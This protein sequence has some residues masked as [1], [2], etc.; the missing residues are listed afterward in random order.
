MNYRL[1]ITILICYTLSTQGCSQ[2]NKLNFVE[3]EEITS[4]AQNLISN[5]LQLLKGKRIGIIA[6]QT[7][8][9]GETHLVDTLTSLDMDII[10]IFSP[11][12]GFRGKAEA[13]ALI[14]DGI[15][16]KTGIQII[17]LY[18]NHKKPTT[19][20]LKGIDLVL[21]DLQ[22]V[23]VRF[24]TYISTLTYIME[25]CGENNI[26]LFVLD[27]PNPN[28]YYVDGPVLKPK[29][30]SFVG[31]HQVPVVYGMTI[32]EYALMVNG[33]F[34]ENSTLNVDMTVIPL[35]GYDHN[36]LFNLPV[37]PSPNLPN[38]QSVYLYPSLCLFEGTVMSIGRGTETPFQVYGHPEF[39]IGDYMFTPKS[40]TGVSENPKFNGIQ[41]YGQ[42]LNNFARNYLSNPQEI[43]LDWLINTFKYLSKKDEFFTSYFEKLAGTDRLREQIINGVSEEE[44]RKSWKKDLKQFKKVREKYLIYN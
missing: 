35:Q 14:K 8:L 12:H 4:G 32:G 3:Y 41:C 43:N 30:S 28:G 15:D 31:L 40:I 24:Y 10:R 16:E 20:D 1:L 17:S 19:D 7:T 2:E 13:G 42:N 23:G 37:I 38:W 36:M 9:V 39:S 34:L 29:F 25:A 5:D 18:G 21:F 44:I 11:E 22:D 33:E 27:R 26:P 6:N